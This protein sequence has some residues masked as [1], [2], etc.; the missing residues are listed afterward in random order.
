MRPAACV[1]ALSLA[2][3]CPAADNPI[4]NG[5]FEAL[6]ARGDPVDWELMGDCSVTD[7][8]HSGERAMLLERDSAEGLCGLNRVW[9]Q[10]SGEQGTMLS[11]LRGGVRFWYKALE[12]SDPAGLIFYVIPMSAEPLEVGGLRAS[13]PIPPQH[14]GDGQ[15]HEGAL[16]YDYADQPGVRWVH[17]SPRLR[18]ARAALI[19]DDIT[20]VDHIGPMPAVRATELRET[21]GREG[22][23][24]A[25]E[26]TLAN[27]GDRPTEEGS[28]SIDLPRGLTTEG[29]VTRSIAPL[30]PGESATVE[31]MVRGRRASQQRITVSFEAAGRLAARELDLGSR[32]EVIGL[33]AGRSVLPV[34]E[35]TQIDL[36]VCNAG[37]AMVTGITADLSAASGLTLRAGGARR[38]LELLR[39]GAEATLSW[40]LAANEQSPAARVQVAVRADNAPPER[41]AT[42]L[43]LA[44]PA[45]AVADASAG[46][47]AEVTDDWALVGNGRVR[48]VFP[49][50]QFGWGIGVVQRRIDGDWQTLATLPRIT[51][52][53]VAGGDAETPV[54]ADNARPVEPTDDAV[55]ALELSGE[56]TDAAGG[57]WR[58]VQTVSFLRDPDRFALRLTATPAA[59]T[60]VLALDGPML[61]AGD[62]APEG[63]RR[64]DAIFPGL[65]WLVEG[66]VSSSD[67]DIAPD[68]AHR[69]RYVPHP[70][71]VTVPV[72]CA[73]F[74][75]PG[76]PDATIWYGWDPLRPYVRDLNRPSAVFASP[77]RFEGRQATTM[78]IFAPSMPEYLDANQ[79]V[80]HT[81]LELAAGEAIELAAQVSVHDATEDDTALAAV[82][83]WFGEHGVPQPN[84]LPHGE[85]LRD[86]VEWSMAAY[87]RSLWVPEEQKWVPILFGPPD[88]RTPRWAPDFLYDVRMGAELA[89]D[90]ALAGEL[91]ER[92]ERV[93]EL[94][95]IAP[96]ADDLGFHYAGPAA[97][98]AGEASVV[99]G[100]IAG[101]REDG[102]WRFRARVETGGVFKGRD[103]GELGPDNAAEVGTC[104]RNAWRVLRFARMTGDASAREAG[105]RALAFMERFEVPRA[106]QVWEV[107]VHT[108]D[109]L[110]SADA[111]EAYLEGYLLTGDRGYLD[112]AVYWAWTG[113]PFV[114]MWDVPGFEFLKYASIPVFG[115]TWYT[116]SWFGRPVQWNGLVYARALLQLAEHDDSLDWRTV[117]EGITVSAM[118]QQYTDPEK[119]ALWPDSI[120]AIDGSDSGANF[121]PRQILRNVYALMGL[122]PVPVTV[123]AETADGPVLVSAAGGL[124]PAQLTD[125][126]LRCEV[127]HEQPQT[128]FTLVCNVSRP[129]AVLV[130]G[131]LAAEVDSPA[132]APAPCWRYLSGEAMLELRLDGSGRH[133]IELVGVSRQASELG[134]RTAT[135]LRFEFDRDAEGWRPSHDLDLLRVSGGILHTRTTGRDPYMV[136]SSCR[137]DAARVGAVRIRMALE[138]GM[139]EGAQL[140]W[141][142]ADDPAFDEAKSVHFRAVA[143]GQFHELV[144]PVGEHPRW[145]GTVTG[146]RLDPSGAEPF[147]RVQIDFIRGE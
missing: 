139:S 136:R 35:S 124:G 65:E 117:A 59:A 126:T 143:D 3:T 106:A 85:D 62:G 76:S 58:I 129:E 73:R 123:A 60:Q 77:D 54:Y 71:M 146:V 10:G 94:S 8:A 45:S 57:G 114:Y 66:E 82:R 63:T 133:E 97:Q 130:N 84:P 138:A 93:V 116:G 109:I 30:A 9:Q 95:G 101:Q 128:G 26:A 67:L 92:Y 47:S 119:Q 17:I 135:E 134:T 1:V 86:E 90:A 23:A 113:L 120:S 14:I 96:V 144:A 19:L 42:Q 43:V 80:A 13:Y 110:A 53:V 140:F 115:A 69:I 103:Y 91:R 11:E 18:G 46:P 28:V 105:L 81:P 108:P 98:M 61:L 100:L 141:T 99:S 147:G 104:A 29:E 15:W 4:T 112:R 25:V 27:A 21:P 16:A 55:C 127:S 12:A 79:R 56:V 51:R 121:A 32:L 131:T 48:I 125:G 88:W 6:D 137:I 49:R 20:W 22:E 52:L 87:L 74:A 89:E 64:L 132:D 2:L 122:Q 34:G 72:M 83:Q 24:C 41:T 50:A 70:H 36:T 37:N 68:H 39:P 33:M 31:W 44:P 145:S 102:S 142:T 38:T 75:V 118:Y 78:G 5:G 7:D 107:P 111:C 40:A